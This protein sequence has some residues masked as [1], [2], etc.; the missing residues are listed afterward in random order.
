LF[1]YY[2]SCLLM[3]YQCFLSAILNSINKL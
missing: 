3:S 2:C 1:E